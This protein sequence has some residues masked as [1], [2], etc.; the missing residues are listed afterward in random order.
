M[1]FS[2]ICAYIIPFCC[3]Y[4]LN[5]TFYSVRLSIHARLNE[6]F[7]N[8]AAHLSAAAMRRFLIS[9]AP[10]TSSWRFSWRL[11]SLWVTFCLHLH[12]LGIETDK[13][14]GKLVN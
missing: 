8:E 6:Y 10:C 5:T 11:T 9:T 13:T 12:K 14:G 1:F 2:Q 4:Q 7:E 3:C